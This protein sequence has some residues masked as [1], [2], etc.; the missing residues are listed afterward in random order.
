MRQ[1]LIDSGPLI[2]TFSPGDRFHAR[3][4][5]QLANWP[6]R[7]VIPEPVLVETCG[8]IRNNYRKGPEYESALLDHV[9]SG[10]GDFVIVMPTSEDLH[11]ARELVRRRVNVP[12]GYVD[13]MVIAMAE[14][15]HITDVAT[16]DL[17][18]VGMAVGPSKIKPISWLVPDP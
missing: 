2:A 5:E 3:C 18:L 16:V 9:C 7:L 6:G 12:L 4:T 17:K 11:R 14:R 1:L 15:L 10:S 13:A 8:F